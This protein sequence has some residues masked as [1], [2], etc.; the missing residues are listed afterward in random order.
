MAR[1]KRGVTTH[2]RHKRLLKLTKGHRGTNHAL[3]KRAHESMMHA[4]A[5][6]YRH[7][8]ELKGDMRRLWIIRVG[9]A[10]REHGMSYSQ[11]IH[12]LKLADISLDRKALADLAMNESA[13]F[14]EVAAA[15]KA[16]L[17]PA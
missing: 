16:K 6:A 10:A 14:A 12:G 2:A 15:A 8:R 7:R 4:L 1:V 11:F 9:A 5:Y 3:Y 13:A 17:A